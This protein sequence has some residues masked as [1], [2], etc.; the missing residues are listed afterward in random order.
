[1]PRTKHGADSLRGSLGQLEP[2]VHGVRRA[3]AVYNS[4]YLELLAASTILVL[5]ADADFSITVPAT[6]GLPPH[7]DGA[8]HAACSV[9]GL[10]RGA[11]RADTLNACSR[12]FLR[13]AQRAKT[14]GITASFTVVCTR[15]LQ[16][17]ATHPSAL[18]PTPLCRRG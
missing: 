13:E 10:R 6:A 1:M 5:A 18:P 2:F 12:I 7:T 15:A 14:C 4:S 16:R 9:T 11:A 3:A 17:V 8:A